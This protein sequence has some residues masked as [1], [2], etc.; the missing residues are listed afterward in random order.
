M[1][2]EPESKPLMGINVCTVYTLSISMKHLLYNT[3]SFT[4]FI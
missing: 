1:V 4:L 2:S 3:L